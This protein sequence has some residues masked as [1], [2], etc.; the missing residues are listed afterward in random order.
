MKRDPHE[1]K[2]AETKQRRLTLISTN[3]Q[4]SGDICISV[5]PHKQQYTLPTAWE[6]L[7]ERWLT[8]LAAGGSPK[9]TQRTRRGHIRKVA[10]ASETRHPVE[11]TLA[12][13]VS[14]CSNPGWSNE[15]RRG[16]RRSVVAFYDW[17]IH[18][19]VVTAN[20][21]A[22]LPKVPQGTPNPRPVPD[23]MWRDI[24][25]AAP[26]RERM[27][28]RLAGEAGMRR[29][30]V[31]VCS[32]NDLVEDLVG[33]SLLV[34]GKGGKQRLVPISAKLAEDIKV[35]CSGG[36][37]FPGNEDGHLS[38]MAVGQLVGKLMPPGWSMHKLRHRFAT[39]KLD[40]PNSNLLL[41]RDLLGH[42]SVATTQ[43]YTKTNES[44]L[45]ALMDGS[46]EF[47]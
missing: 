10:K 45:R 16:V 14:I 27:M 34:H 15:H 24:M 36:F 18:E 30:E 46:D 31:A 23:S 38:P 9:P 12:M 17:L 3:K 6:M 2:F 42:A 33:Y 44:A 47:Y 7:V 8:W 32:R 28:M 1:S 43:I 20:P 5:S 26:T 11:V 37:L 19:G 35:F 4:T 13:L 25:I 21:A 41:V 39:K 22:G 40:R 29:S